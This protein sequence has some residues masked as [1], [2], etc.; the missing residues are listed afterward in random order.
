MAEAITMLERCGTSTSAS[1]TGS[2][3][4]SSI[5]FHL[6]IQ[7]CKWQS[8]LDKQEARELASVLWV[9]SHWLCSISS[10]LTIPHHVLCTSTI[11]ACVCA[12]CSGLTLP[13]IQACLFMVHWLFIHDWYWLKLSCAVGHLSRPI[14]R[15]GS[16]IMTDTASHVGHW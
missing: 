13:I 11:H 6:C 7:Y 15:C 4:S 1:V 10:T 16:L 5:L 3:P 9:T 8:I 2:L 14:G 12:L